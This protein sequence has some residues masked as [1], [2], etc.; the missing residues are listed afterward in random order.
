MS[1]AKKLVIIVYTN[2]VVKENSVEV[3]RDFMIPHI[4]AMSENE[5]FAI[6]GRIVT[7]I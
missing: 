1:N 3:T 2:P 4:V 7:F 6:H 5:L